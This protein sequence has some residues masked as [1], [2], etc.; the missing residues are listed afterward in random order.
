[1]VKKSR[2]IFIDPFKWQCQQAFHSASV[3]R[4]FVHILHFQLHCS[5]IIMK[6]VNTVKVYIAVTGV[7]GF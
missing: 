1:M 3:V 6:N 7:V 5:S 4:L 2:Q